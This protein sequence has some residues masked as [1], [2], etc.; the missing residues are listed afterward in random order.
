MAAHHLSVDHLERFHVK[1]AIC[2][3]DSRDAA[4][5]D[6]PESADVLER[7]TESASDQ[8]RQAFAEWSQHEA[9]ASFCAEFD[10]PVERVVKTKASGRRHFSSGCLTALVGIA[11][12]ERAPITPSPRSRRAR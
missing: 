7:F 3:E 12:P 1:L 8:E 10:E 6:D 2:Y 11:P 9:L 5:P 4:A